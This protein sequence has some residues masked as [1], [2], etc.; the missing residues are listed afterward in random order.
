MKEIDRFLH[1]TVCD[2]G[3]RVA[4]LKSTIV[5]YVEGP[6]KETKLFIKD[7][8][9]WQTVSMSYDDVKKCLTENVA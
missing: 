7:V 2:T 9:Q 1:S 6:Q 5:G 8:D 4:V 3:E